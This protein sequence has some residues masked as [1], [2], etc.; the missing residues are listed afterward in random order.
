[1]SI[2]DEQEIERLRRVNEELRQAVKRMQGQLGFAEVLLSVARC[3]KPDIM[4][5]QIWD[6]QQKQWLKEFSK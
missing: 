1:M 2:H 4:S 5:V 3:N 6:N